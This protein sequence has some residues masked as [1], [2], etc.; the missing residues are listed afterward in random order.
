MSGLPTSARIVDTHAHIWPRGLLHS[1]QRHAA[2]LAAT[3]ADLLATMDAAG[4]DAVIVSPAMLAYPANAYVL[5]A[6]GTV[7]ERIFAVAGINPRDPEA[8]RSIPFVAA[9]GA[10]GV[11]VNTG[12]TPLATD[13][14]LEGLDSLVDAAD[15]EDVVIQWTIPLSASHL[16]ERAAARRPGVRHVLDHLGL[17]ADPRDLTGLAR[18]RAIAAITSVNVKLSGMYAFSRDGYPYRDA[19][20]WAEGV[21][22]AFGPD[23]T[24]WASDWPLADESASYADHLALVGLLPFLDADARRAILRDT[25]LRV[26]QRARPGAG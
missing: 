24:M 26:W 11:R 4:V 10:L 15:V 17:P 16:I 14:D 13:E 3:P 8:V 6:A 22:G 7:P 2:T 21:I 20:P 1:G 23:R 12:A 19:W 9:Q 18:I 5:G 25:A